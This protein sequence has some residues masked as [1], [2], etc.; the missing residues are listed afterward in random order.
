MNARDL[1]SRGQDDDQQRR[2][3]RHRELLDILKLV[4]WVIFEA[5]KDVIGQGGPGSWGL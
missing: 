4:A 3:W 5:I 2:Y 1:H